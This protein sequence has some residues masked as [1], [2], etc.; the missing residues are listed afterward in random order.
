MKIAAL[1]FDQEAERDAS[2]CE[3]RFIAS[4]RVIESKSGLNFFHA[5][6]ATQQDKLETGPATLLSDLGCPA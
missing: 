6:T 1:V 3:E 5:P 4:A 2:F